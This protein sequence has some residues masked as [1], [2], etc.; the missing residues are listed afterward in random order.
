[1][2]LVDEKYQK[3]PSY[4]NEG[5]ALAVHG[6]GRL[7]FVDFAEYDAASVVSR[8]KARRGAYTVDRRGRPRSARS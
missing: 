3:P 5:P 1:M 7:D 2:L 6:F 4:L 8:M